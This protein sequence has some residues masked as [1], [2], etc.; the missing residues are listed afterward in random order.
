MSIS[1]TRRRNC[2]RLAGPAFA[3]LILF[4]SGCVVREDVDVPF[5]RYLDQPPEIRVLI[6]EESSRIP[7]YAPA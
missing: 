5:H 3:G 1:A 4:L 2:F 7:L 6:A